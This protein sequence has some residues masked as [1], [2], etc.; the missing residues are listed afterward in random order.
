MER[1]YQ[2]VVIEVHQIFI[3]APNYGT[4]TVK[5]DDELSPHIKEVDLNLS[6][7]LTRVIWSRF[8]FIIT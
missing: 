1:V 5:N 8:G 6:R 2:Q 3:L 7:G 4:V